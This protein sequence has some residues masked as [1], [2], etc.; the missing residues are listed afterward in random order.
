MVEAVTTTVDVWVVV[1]G[2]VSAVAVVGDVKGGAEEPP[3]SVGFKFPGGGVE[4]GVDAA[5]EVEPGEPVGT[6]DGTAG[7]VDED[8]SLI[9]VN[10][11]LALPESPNTVMNVEDGVLCSNVA[12][13][14]RQQYSLFRW[15]H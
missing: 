5:G 2:L 15:G 10:S 3:E 12:D 8:A 6:G 9:I 1:V 11:G 13:T 7:V 14:Y 4:L